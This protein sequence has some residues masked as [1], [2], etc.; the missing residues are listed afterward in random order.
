MKM[1]VAII[2]PEKLAAVKK[3][4]S[5]VGVEGV[6]I[7]DVRGH[8]SQSGITITTRVGS[9]VIDEIEKTK[10]ETVVDDALEQPCI[11]ARPSWTMLW[12]NP[13]SMR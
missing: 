10:I 4:L 8:G 12:S 5:E 7:T 2:R 3:G 1:I 11:D 6:T 13:A 9:T